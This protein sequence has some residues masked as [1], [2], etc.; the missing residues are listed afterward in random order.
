[1]QEIHLGIGSTPEEE[2]GFFLGEVSAG[3]FITGNALASAIGLTA[4]T[5]QHSDEPW[6]KFL[7]L[8]DGKTK[9]VAKKTFRH[10][11]S[12][13]QINAV[14]AVYGD[15]S[16]EING[17]SFKV[18]LLKGAS[19]DPVE[20]ISGYDTVSSH[21]SEWNR[22]FYPLVPNTA[23]SN[24]I[25]TYPISGEGIRFG[26]WANYTDAELDNSSRWT[27]CQETNASNTS[28]RVRRG[29][30]GLSYFGLAGSSNAYSYYAWRPV[31][32]LV[33]D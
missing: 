27:W 19:G 31:L 10:T 4:G 1:M 15:R 6:L 33:E 32:E 30:S 21:G 16:I 12:W 29:N 20:G 23:N 18:R 13:D 25:P 24:K 3:A 2:L 14:N 8:V 5:A 11:I 17:E 9:Y 22:L 26:A 28:Q 7:D